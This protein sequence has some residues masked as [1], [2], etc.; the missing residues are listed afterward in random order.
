MNMHYVQGYALRSEMNEVSFFQNLFGQ[1]SC[2]F[3]IL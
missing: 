1:E 3:L 2:G